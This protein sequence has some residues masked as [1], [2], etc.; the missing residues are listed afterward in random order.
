[1]TKRIAFEEFNRL[2]QAN[3]IT[4]DQ[5]DDYLEMAPDSDDIQVQFRSGALTDYPPDNY[6]VDRE[7]YELQRRADEQEQ[8]ENIGVLAAKPKIVMDGDSWFE[9][10][11]IFRPREIGDWLKKSKLYNIDRPSHWG[12]EIK[13]IYKEKDYIESLN[14]FRPDALLI[15]GGGND[16]KN[17]ISRAVHDFDA[18][19]PINQYLTN[20]GQQLFDEIKDLYHSIIVEANETF[21]TNIVIYGYDY[22]RPDNNGKYIGKKLKV[23]GFPEDQ[24][25]PI[26]NEIINSF[27]INI[28]G[29]AN[30]YQKVTYLNCL[31]VTNAF[32]WYD[33]MHPGK[34]GYEALSQHFISHLQNII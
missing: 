1:M 10:P 28:A 3:K 33:D 11:N 13:D 23:K 14:K 22:P 32:P 26:T 17:N 18:N 12:D 16:L 20:D 21:E 2:I 24:M 5:L 7:I 8:L 15:S 6:D 25:I 31:G 4:T 27:N 29:I 30:Q 34:D 9:M 19:R